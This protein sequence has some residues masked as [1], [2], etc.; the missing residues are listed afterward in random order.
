[1]A[2]AW[3]SHGRPVAAVQLTR[4]CRAVS[5]QP[6]RGAHTP[7]VNGCQFHTQH[8]AVTSRDQQNQVNLKLIKS[9]CH[10][11]F[12]I[13]QWFGNTSAAFC[14]PVV[15]VKRQLEGSDVNSLLLVA[16]HKCFMDSETLALQVGALLYTACLLC[17]GVRL[18][19]EAH[20][21]LGRAATVRVIHGQRDSCTA[22]K[23]VVVHN[24]SALQGGRTVVWV[25]CA[26]GCAI[27]FSDD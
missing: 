6:A 13:A 12:S 7:T 1:M 11:S 14:A 23:C 15:M 21:V 16:R 5:P 27:K 22:S 19:F 24:V 8:G 17:R 3:P 25:T 18:W 9:A 20:V 10:S 4:G 2:A 26:V